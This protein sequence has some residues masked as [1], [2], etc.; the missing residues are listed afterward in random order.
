MSIGEVALGL[1]LRRRFGFQ[2]S[3]YWMLV[4][5]VEHQNWDSAMMTNFIYSSIGFTGTNITL[6][7]A[8]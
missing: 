7:V 8:F 1:K 5:L 3:N 6:G 2:Q 4:I